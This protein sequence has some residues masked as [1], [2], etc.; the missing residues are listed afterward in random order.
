MKAG[1]ELPK[2]HEAE[3]GA[4]GKRKSTRPSPE[5][6]IPAFPGDCWPSANEAK[7]H[8]YKPVKDWFMAFRS[9]GQNMSEPAERKHVAELSRLQKQFIQD[10][11]S[12]SEEELK[13]CCGEAFPAVSGGARSAEAVWPNRTLAQ[14][15]SLRDSELLAWKRVGEHHERR[16]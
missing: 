10:G 15:Y 1:A 16:K 2:W 12:E 11:D 13:S 14:P 7:I 8:G 9:K 4:P 3:V 6:G 5:V